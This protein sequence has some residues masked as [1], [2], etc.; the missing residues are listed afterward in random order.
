MGSD[1]V[2]LHWLCP[3]KDLGNGLRLLY[4]DNVCLLMSDVITGREIADVFVELWQ[5]NWKHSQVMRE[6]MVKQTRWE[7]EQLL[8]LMMVA[9]MKCNS[10]G[11]RRQALSKA[12]QSN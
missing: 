12:T 2:L 5:C 10:L 6:V 9:Q 11:R 8:M 3:G 1:D 4:D 7:E